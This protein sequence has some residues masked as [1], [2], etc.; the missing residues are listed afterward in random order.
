[1]YLCSLIGERFQRFGFR[2]ILH[3]VK[4]EAV[5]RIHS[6]TSLLAV[7]RCVRVG[8]IGECKQLDTRL[9]KWVCYLLLTLRIID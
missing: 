2:R 9:C 7:A 3:T 4:N 8:L 5:F 1:M 6:A